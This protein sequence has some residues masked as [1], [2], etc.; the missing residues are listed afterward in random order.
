MATPLLSGEQK[1]EEGVHV[2]AIKAQ[3]VTNI[4]QSPSETFRVESRDAWLNN[5]SDQSSHWLTVSPYL[6]S[7]HLLDLHSVDTPNRLLALA[8]MHLEPATGD[9]AIVK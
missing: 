5:N 3:N 7:P 2:R 8:S 1:V 4:E 6:E 9:Y